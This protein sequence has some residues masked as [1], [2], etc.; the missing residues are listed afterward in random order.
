MKSIDNL[1]TQ[2]STQTSLVII[3]PVE[4][5]VNRSPFTAF[6]Y[7]IVEGL[8]SII[9]Q[10]VDRILSGFLKIF[11]LFSKKKIEQSVTPIKHIDPSILSSP[12]TQPDTI[13]EENKQVVS[14][15]IEGILQEFFVG[16]PSLVSSSEQLQDG[17]MTDSLNTSMTDS[18]LL[19]LSSILEVSFPQDPPS[20]TESMEMAPAFVDFFQ[21]RRELDEELNKL[22]LINEGLLEQKP[23]G[24]MFRIWIEKQIRGYVNTVHRDYLPNLI[25][26][27]RK[28]EQQ[29]SIVV[30]RQLLE[31]VT[32][33][34]QK[35]PEI[36]KQQLEEKIREIR[37]VW[38]PYSEQ[39]NKL[40]SDEEIV[41]RL[42]EEEAFRVKELEKKR[43]SEALGKMRREA[44]KIANAPSVGQLPL[45]YPNDF[46]LE[47]EF[48]K[49]S[50]LNAT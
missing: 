18:N 1:S 46:H 47:E 14:S 5:I 19:S 31:F 39:M 28:L 32:H 49:L 25:K 41:A 20:L 6:V 9:T 44:W 30:T 16:R 36:S 2:N 48:L 37:A 7:S 40:V 15:L 11:S 12:G 34:L 13:H 29:Q 3:G 27:E 17:V 4:K 38:D 23:D 50:N 8:R 26:S 42:R 21:L 22:M 35:G 45:W 43:A 33:V 24:M 10:I